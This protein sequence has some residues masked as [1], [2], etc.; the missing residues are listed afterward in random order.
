VLRAAF[1]AAL[2][3]L[4]WATPTLGQ[5]TDATLPS[6]CTDQKVAPVSVIISCGSANL[7]A[8]EL[9]WSSWGAATSTATGVMSVNTCDPNCAAGNRK[10]FPVQLTASGLRDCPFGKPQYTRLDY[11]FPTPTTVP[12]L[13]DDG[14]NLACPRRPHADP[15][16]KRMRLRFSIRGG[17]TFIARIRLRVCAVRGDASVEVVEHLLLGGRVFAERS[18]SIDFRQRARCQRHTFH[19]PLR[20]EFV[21]VGRYRVAATVWDR[22]AQRSRT[23]RRS[24]LTAD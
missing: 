16:I 4:A 21:G 22:D 6:R 5:V 19:W 23:V 10:A 7:Y 17:D 15:K 12:G 14:L 2:S 9:A 8:D 24:S 11:D 18:R 13:G 1:L 3:V 20:H